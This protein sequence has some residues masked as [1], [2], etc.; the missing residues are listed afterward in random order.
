M[1]EREMNRDI[2]ILV[3]H[4]QGTIEEA[5]LGLVAE[6]ENL[7]TRLKLD[8]SIIA[9]SMGSELIEELETL[10]SYGVDKLLNLEAKTLQ[11]YHG[12]L[13]SAVLSG[14]VGKYSPFCILAYQSAELD[15]LTPRL[16]AS[17]NTPL[18][19]RVV[20]LNLTPDGQICVVR[21]VSNGY[22]FEEIVL[23]ASYPQLISFLPSALSTPEKRD[24]IP[25]EIINEP[26]E[27]YQTDLKTSRLE[28]IEADPRNLDLEEADIIIAGGRGVGKDEA[29]NII[30]ELADTIGGTVGATRPVIDCETLP[31]ERQIGQTGK[32]VTPR[33]IINCGIS[34]AN[35]YTAGIEKSQKV[36]AVDKNPRARI[37][38]FADLGIVGDVQEIIPRLIKEL[39]E[40]NSMNSNE[41]RL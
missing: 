20:D 21:P 9:V 39:K 32:T 34:G 38:R 24:S 30:H 28:I 6:A 41:K 35:E 27:N 14:L 3:Q 8:S 22:L 25:M 15:D 29:F 37:F 12:E 13:F 18:A 19:N 23:S 36:I 26:L 31:F 7:R 16:A 10:G 33:L 40:E 1:P 17:L 5:T 2:W 4:R 11:Q